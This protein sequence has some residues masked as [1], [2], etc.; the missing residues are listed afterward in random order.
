MSIE[1]AF[2]PQSTVNIAATT[3]SQN[4]ALPA[5]TIASYQ[6]AGGD[7][8]LVYNSGTTVALV[9]FGSDNTV[10]ATVGAGFPI[11]PGYHRLV[12]AGQYVT[13]AAAIMASSTGTVYFSR[14]SGHVY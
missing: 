8:L 4:V 10:V 3:T 12:G 1:A 11:P 14:G 5:T 6:T 9:A 13:Y 2:F 7:A